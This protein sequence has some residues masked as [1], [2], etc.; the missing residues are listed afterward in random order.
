MIPP[1][2]PL[3]LFRGFGER[4]RL[5]LKKKKNENKYTDQKIYEMLLLHTENI[6]LFL[7]PF[8]IK[9]FL[10]VKTHNPTYL[11]HRTSSC[12][13]RPVPERSCQRVASR[14]CSVRTGEG[15]WASVDRRST[16]VSTRRFQGRTDTWSLRRGTSYLKIPYRCPVRVNISGKLLLPDM[17][18]WRLP[19]GPKLLVPSKRLTSTPV[20]YRLLLLPKVNILF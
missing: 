19:P 7:I 8:V 16:T 15:A 18:R 13:R 2:L 1:R 6:S 9:Y 4:P 5:E 12:I 14:E 17:G 3:I 11:C 10:S 20:I